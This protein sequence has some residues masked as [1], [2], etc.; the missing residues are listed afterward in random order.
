MKFYKYSSITN[1]YQKKDV[2]K[3][4]VEMKLQNVENKWIVTEKIHGVNF[5]IMTD[6]S[7]IIYSKRTSIIGEDASFFSWQKAFDKEKDEKKVKEIYKHIKGLYKNVS[8]ITIHGELFGGVYPHKEVKKETNI[9]KVQKDVYYSPKT[10]FL[11]F[12]VS[13]IIGE[14]KKYL[15]K[16]LF[17]GI[18]KKYNFDFIP[19]RYCGTLE[20]CLEQPNS[21]ESLIH[22]MYKLPPIENNICEGIVIAPVKRFKLYG[23]DS[24]YAIFKSKN[25]KFKEKSKGKNKG[26]N[27]RQPNIDPALLELIS[28]ISCY[29]NQNRLNNVISKIGDV[30]MKDFKQVLIEFNNDVYDDYEKENSK[31]DVS[32]D[33]KKK[34]D[35]YINKQIATLIKTYLMS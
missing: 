11:A 32:K 8:Q 4:Q 28:K 23:N 7:E 15:D 27:G 3:A 26:K 21:F 14:E 12:D 2:M 6:G 24:S 19:M 34:I 16:D 13:Y 33:D 20:E 29:V 10:N 5:G 18:L 1:H 25:E 30:T 31:L 35:K 9:K 17:F 22:K